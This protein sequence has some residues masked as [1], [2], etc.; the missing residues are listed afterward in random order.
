LGRAVVESGGDAQI[1]VRSMQKALGPRG[2]GI[3]LQAPDRF[4]V[5]AFPE[6]RSFVR[7]LASRHRYVCPLWGADLHAVV[8]DGN[9]ALGQG[10][11]RT[12][13]F[14]ESAD[15]FGKLMGEAAPSLAVL[16]GLGLALARLGRYDQAFKH[17]RTAH[18]LEQ[19]RD[20][21]TAGYL[22]LCGAKGKPARE[23]DKA[24]NVAWAI[25]VVAQFSAP[26]DVEWAG[27]LNDI[28][29]EARA[30]DMAVAPADQLYLCDHLMS[31]S[32]TDPLAADA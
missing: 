25:R 24:R 26:G 28:F 29:A 23:E 6:A 32:A 30:L 1:A 16:R 3:W 17:L 5:E 22:A 20:R 14:Q 4:W 15:V 9:T 19:P 10:L 13:A 7:K 27:L 2:L 21:L 12:G 11:Y 8:R 31:V 18:E